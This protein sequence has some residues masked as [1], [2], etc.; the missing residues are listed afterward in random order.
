M[1]RVH[2]Y[3]YLMLYNDFFII[4]EIY[5]FIYCITFIWLFDMEQLINILLLV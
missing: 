5:N 2:A 4:Y 1:T 3:N